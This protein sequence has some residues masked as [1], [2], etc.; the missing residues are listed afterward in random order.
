MVRYVIKEVERIK[1]DLEKSSS[2]SSSAASSSQH[3]VALQKKHENLKATKFQ[4]LKLSQLSL[5]QLV[6]RVA[7]KS[8]Y[9]LSLYS[10]YL[11][12]YSGDKTCPVVN[13]LDFGQSSENCSN[14]LKMK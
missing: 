12:R 8:E 11:L 2:S 5:L 10:N 14:S 4:N 6:I 9:L 13:V 1:T 3:P 7:N